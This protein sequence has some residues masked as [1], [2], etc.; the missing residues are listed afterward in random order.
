MYVDDVKY[1]TLDTTKSFDDDSD[2]G[3]Y[4]LPMYLMISGASAFTSG[5]T[6]FPYTGAILSNESLPLTQSIDWVRLYQDPAVT[7][8]QLNVRK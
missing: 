1:W 7:G 3:C 8:S 4:D 6:W 2:T 5:S